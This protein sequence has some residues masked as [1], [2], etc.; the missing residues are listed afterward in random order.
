[1][2]ALAG[3]C[4]LAAGRGLGDP[5]APEAQPWRDAPAP[6]PAAAPDAR[7]EPPAAAPAPAR[8]AAGCGA[9]RALEA[10]PWRGAPAPAPA[11]APDARRGSPAAGTERVT[12]AP[13]AAVTAPA[14]SAAGY[15][16]D[17]RPALAGPAA[18]RRSKR[19]G[20]RSLSRTAAT[21]R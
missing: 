7:R 6:A 18:G 14:R 17:A 4:V 16:P 10:Q 21:V 12:E 1:R 3:P 15:A 5:R 13:L 9:R 11:A 20:G 8:S 2:S 19:L